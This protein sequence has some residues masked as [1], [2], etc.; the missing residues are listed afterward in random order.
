MDR[1]INL[2]VSQFF[3]GKEAKLNTK[4]LKHL[5]REG[6]LAA[7]DLTKII[8]AESYHTTTKP[9]VVSRRAKALVGEEYLEVVGTKKAT[10][11]KMEASIYGIGFKG[12]LLIPILEGAPNLV[13]IAKANP[14]YLLACLLEQNG[15]RNFAQTWIVSGL[16]TIIEKGLLNPDLIEDIDGYP[17]IFLYLLNRL[18]EPEIKEM[19]DP[20][21]SER[22]SQT[23]QS[24][25][26]K[27]IQKLLKISLGAPLLNLLPLVGEQELEM[28]PDI[29]TKAI[30]EWASGKN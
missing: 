11:N 26:G 3:R 10:K 24:E 7:W 9:S 2:R 20:Q 15:A 5:G 28:T 12:S 13:N 19:L 4:I 6:P 1:S 27:D 16:K 23:L 22:V 17:M 25:E 29:I 18:G 14:F 21:L 8:K 30:F